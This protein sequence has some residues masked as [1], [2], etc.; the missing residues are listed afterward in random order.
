MHLIVEIHDRV[1][2]GH[3]EFKFVANPIGA[4]G[5]FVTER[6]ELI[7]SRPISHSRLTFYDRPWLIYRARLGSRVGR[8]LSVV[9]AVENGCQNRQRRLE[10]RVHFA[11]R[12]SSNR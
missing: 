4:G 8:D 12:F 5:V 3:D 9:L 6:S 7:R 10:V 2:V 11:I 1:A